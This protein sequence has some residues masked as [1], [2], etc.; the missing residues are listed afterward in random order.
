LVTSLITVSLTSVLL[1]FG[2]NDTM[3]EIGGIAKK[4]KTIFCYQR[5]RIIGILTIYVSISF[6]NQ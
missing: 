1:N 4:K 3:A 5:K 6:S 2:H